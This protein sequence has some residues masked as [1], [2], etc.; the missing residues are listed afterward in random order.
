LERDALIACKWVCDTTATA[1]LL[2][3]L[4]ADVSMFHVSRFKFRLISHFSEIS[5][6]EAPRP[7]MAHP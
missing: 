5:F 3:L 4:L 1:R 6:T 7:E 2:L